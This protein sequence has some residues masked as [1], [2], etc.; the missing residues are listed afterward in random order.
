LDLDLLLYNSMN[1]AEPGLRVPHPELLHR[2]FALEPLLEVWPDAKL[3]SGEPLSQFIPAVADQ[4]LERWTPAATTG[5]AVFNR[6]AFLVP[7]IA[8][9][10]VVWWAVGWLVNQVL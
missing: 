10:L 3:P 7:M 8:L 5:R 1:I 4:Q 2:R 6:F 9:I